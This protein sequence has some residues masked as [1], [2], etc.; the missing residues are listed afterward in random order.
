MI[1]VLKIMQIRGEYEGG[2][3]EKAEGREGKET[4]RRR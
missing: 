4:R 1:T 2:R 3:I